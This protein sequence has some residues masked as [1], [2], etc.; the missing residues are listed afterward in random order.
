MGVIGALRSEIA[1]PA[2]FVILASAFN[3]SIGLPAAFGLLR[4]RQQFKSNQAEDVPKID[5]SKT[6]FVFPKKSIQEI[7][8]FLKEKLPGH[9]E[10]TVSDGKQTEIRIQDGI[11]RGVWLEITSDAQQSHL[12]R[13][14][15]YIPSLIAKVIILVVSV[16]VFSI[17]T[18]DVLFAVIGKFVPMSVGLGGAAGFGMYIIV[19]HI[20]IVM[21]KNSWSGELH[22]TIETLQA[23]PAND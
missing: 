2:Q 23:K 11:W 20:F 19:K 21:I 6:T 3:F 5:L 16:A 1:V 18:M 13:L 10:V 8:A 9:T 12:T 4:D 22:Q 15:Y 17:M 14:S 7:Q